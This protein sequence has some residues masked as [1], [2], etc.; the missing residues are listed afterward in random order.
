VR[1]IDLFTRLKE[2][3]PSRCPWGMTAYRPR[4]RCVRAATK[5]HRKLVVGYAAFPQWLYGN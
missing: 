2:V 4:V 3:H 5:Q 1:K